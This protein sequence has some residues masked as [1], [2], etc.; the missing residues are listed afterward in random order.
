MA[1][2]LAGAAA[3]FLLLT[4][5]FLLWQSHAAQRSILPSAPPARSG[6]PFMVAQGTALEAPEAS[7]ASREAKRF[8]RADKN[9][10]GKIEASELLD[11]RRKAF[12]KLDTNGDGRLSF[13]EWAVK[14]IAKIQTADGDR[15]GWLSAAE[16]STTAPPPPKH[17][18]CACSKSYASR[19]NSDD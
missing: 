16:Y 9:K 13:E 5:A 4:G 17:A 15:N 6:Q 18:S 3:C 8:S 2:F 19:D 11:P 10:D 7:P 14:T 1:R 12:A